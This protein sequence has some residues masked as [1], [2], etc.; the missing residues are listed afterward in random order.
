M[1]LILRNIAAVLE[2]L[3]GARVGC[4]GDVM[5]DRYIIGSVERISPEAPVPVLHVEREDAMP[6]GAGNVVRNLAALGARIRFASVI[7]DDDAGRALQ[8]RL[9]ALEGVERAAL[10]IEPERRT[11]VK[12]RFLAQGQQLLR[13]DDETAKPLPPQQRRALL[14]AV[15]NWR[16]ASPAAIVLSD[17]AKGVLLDG[18]AGALI[19]LSR[20]QGALVV[21]DPKGADFSRY[22][23]AN[24]ITPNRHELAIAAGGGV[25]PGQEAACARALRTRHDL[26]A[27]LVTLGR[28]GMLLIDEKD[29]ALALPADARD[30]F[31]VSGAGD[32]VA[33]TL[34]AALAA[35]ATLP[36]AAALAN[37]AAGIV[38]SKV[39]T[40]VVR[41]AELADASR[42]S[43]LRNFEAK[44]CDRATVA[45]RAAVWRRQG[46]SVGFTNGCFDLIHPGHVSLLEQAKAECDRLVVGLN[47]DASVARL[48]G[49]GRPVQP[50]A[51]RAT[52]LASLMAVDA[53]VPFAEDTPLETIL[54]VRPDV[55]VKGADYRLEQVVGAK[56]VQ[57]W[58]GRVHLARLE[59]GFSTTATI[60]S[61]APLP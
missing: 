27:V 46:L 60:A 33:A 47:T 56:D 35:G 30:V 15:A 12:T 34:A 5:L 17:Y 8:E 11:T 40:A 31:D 24:I 42:R 48:K 21:I 55:L 49:A 58:G 50:E 45:E 59:P 29:E 37:A 2:K 36:E 14:E 13:A 53:V 3:P 61:L 22:R 32:T 23:G 16:D 43:T 54:A 18:L 25:A 6:G 26:S 1:S 52:V 7:G 41:I 57:R 9:S 19:E 38:V 20:A 4:V 44:V 28:D 10:L 39:G 51:A